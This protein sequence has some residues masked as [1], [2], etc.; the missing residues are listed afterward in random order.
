M[1]INFD[2]LQRK[3]NPKAKSQAGKT[4]DP[5]PTALTAFAGI[6][7]MAFIPGGSGNPR[8]AAAGPVPPLGRAQ[9]SAPVPGEDASP[10]GGVG[11]STRAARRAAVT[12]RP[13]PE[14]CA[15]P[16]GGRGKMSAGAATRA[17]CVA[18]RRRRR[19]KRRKRRGAARPPP[20]RGH[21]RSSGA[22]YL[23]PAGV[24]GAG[25]E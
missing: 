24:P 2:L 3:N 21:A 25:F 5:L 18:R 6:V 4:V 19:K 9:R 10:G 12:R 17:A 13:G 11:R 15:A 22:P 23:R 1:E 7:I 16:R 8:N 20:P 14:R